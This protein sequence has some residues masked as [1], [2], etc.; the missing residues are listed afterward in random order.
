MST[1]RSLLAGAAAALALTG[2]IAACSSGGAAADEGQGAPETTPSV[3]T[4]PESPSAPTNTEFSNATE[5]TR[6]VAT[7]HNARAGSMVAANSAA[8]RY[9]AHQIA[10]QRAQELAGTDTTVDPGTVTIKPNDKDSSI[11]V[12]TEAVEGQSKASK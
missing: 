3:S 9:V 12:E 5:F 1:R 4:P 11:T 10:L 6:L 8:A 2:L 7:G